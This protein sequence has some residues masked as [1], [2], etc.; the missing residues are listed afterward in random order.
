MDT[1]KALVSK[2]KKRFIDEKNGFNLDLTYIGGTQ[3]Q[4]IA[5]GYP[6]EGVEALYRNS[7]AEV[8]RFFSTFHKGKVAVYNL[9]S[10]RL[11]DLTG[12]FDKCYRFGFEDHNPCPLD[13]IKPFC[14][15]VGDWLNENPDNV[16][17]VHCKAGKGRTGLMV[18]CYLVHSGKGATADEALFYFGEERTK[19]GK[20]VTIPS[21]MR[22]VHY[23]EQLLKRGSITPYTYQITH[24]RFVTVPSF[25]NSLLMGGGCNPYF[26]VVLAW[27]DDKMQANKRCVYN[28]KKHVK[29]IRHFKKDERF[30]DLDCSGDNLLVCGDVK[31]QFY[32]K[33]RYNADDKMFH[34]WFH[35]GFIENNYLCF[36]KSVLD[37]ACKDKDNKKF[38]PN[39]KLEVFLHRVDKDVRPWEMVDDGDEHQH[40]AAAAAAGSAGAGAAD[41]GDDN[42]DDE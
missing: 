3:S 17:A 15:S 22:Y 10:E 39:F 21:Q 31:L 14:E 25:D 5:M 4:I 13:L 34:V 26:E 12:Y 33:D 8:Q 28:Y 16:A 42:S 32:D 41:L 40:K 29:K 38:D 23:Y 27:L 7:M 18:S 9:C 36:E 20:G 35:T 6:A 1:V 19:N 24:I 30:V 37:K 11:Y 2:K